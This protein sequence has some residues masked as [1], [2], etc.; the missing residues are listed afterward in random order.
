MYLYYL[1]HN[2]PVLLDVVVRRLHCRGRGQKVNLTLS[3]S[4]PHC[5]NHQPGD[6]TG[7]TGR[8][9]SR[10][11]ALICKFLQRGEFLA[12]I[13][14]EKARLTNSNCQIVADVR[15]DKSEPVVNVTFNDGEKLTMKGTN[16]TF[17]ELI[18]FFSERCAMKDPQAQE[19]MV[20]K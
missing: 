18:S 16:L 20:S 4:R 2:R 13:G 6:H 1:L 17:K 5:R 8:N 19:T 12:A 9:I 15:H 7:P 3:P 10:V 11:F 14:T